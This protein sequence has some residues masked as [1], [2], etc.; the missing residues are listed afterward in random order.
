MNR[1]LWHLLLT[2]SSSHEGVFFNPRVW[3]ESWPTFYQALIFRPGVDKKNFLWT[4]LK[5][6]TV[7]LQKE[8]QGGYA[9]T[10]QQ[11]KPALGKRNAV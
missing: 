6:T 5:K 2:P 11:N 4:T 1:A 3:I 9:K 10:L 8:L 7:P